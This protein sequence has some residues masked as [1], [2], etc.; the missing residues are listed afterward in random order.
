MISLDGDALPKGY[1]D[2]MDLPY[3]AVA[4]TTHG[5]TPEN[6]RARFIFPL[7]RDISAEEYAA[8]ARYLA[9]MLGIDY[10][11]NAPICQTS[12]CSGQV[13]QAM[14]NICVWR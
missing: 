9:Q 13:L 1:L 8:V 11:T 3:T 12:L 2:T 7:T 10:L 5:H 6:P 4:Y 14:E